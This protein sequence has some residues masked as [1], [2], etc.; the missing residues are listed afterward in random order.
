[1]P[2]TLTSLSDIEMEWRECFRLHLLQGS[3]DVSFA[4]R[5]MFCAPQTR[6]PLGGQLHAAAAHRA[7]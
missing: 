1:V 4:Y 2:A 7:L 5:R 6:L 3:D